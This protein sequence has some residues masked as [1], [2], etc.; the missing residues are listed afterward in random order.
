MVGSK[1]GDVKAEALGGVVVLGE[2][3]AGLGL[4]FFREDEDEV[5]VERGFGSRYSDFD[6]LSLEGRWSTKKNCEEERGEG[7]QAGFLWRR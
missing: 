6:F 2:L 1:V 7:S 3:E 4:V 5:A